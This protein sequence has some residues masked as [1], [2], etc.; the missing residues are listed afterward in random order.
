MSKFSVLITG[1]RGYIGQNL[2]KFLED[3]GIHCVIWD[4]KN[5]KQVEELALIP[6]EAVVHLAALP[7]VA[8]CKNDMKSAVRDNILATLSLFHITETK[9]VIFASS[10]AANEP[11]ANFYATCKY[12]AEEEAFRLNKLGTRIKVMRFSNVF[13]G[14][15][16]IDNKTSVVAKFAKAKLNKKSI[17]INGNGLQ[18]RDFIHVDD[19]CNAIYLG[20]TKTD[21]ELYNEPIEI[22]SGNKTSILELAKMF[23][24]DYRFDLGSDMVGVSEAFANTERAKNLLGFNVSKKIEDYVKVIPT[25]S[26]S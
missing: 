21:D 23:D 20:L 11:N 6:T 25:I 12:I 14:E 22:G 15:G 2:Q 9:E 8:G 26:S 10:G 4:S 7:S 24:C 13:G 17:V 18:K 3:K 16:Y 19:I 1:G 5:D